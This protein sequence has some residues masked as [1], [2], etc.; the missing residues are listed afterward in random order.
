M[1][2]SLAGVLASIIALSNATAQA[3]TVHQPSPHA[4]NS[5]TFGTL[6]SGAIGMPNGATDVPGPT[7]NEVNQIYRVF[8]SSVDSAGI[9]TSGFAG[10]LYASF[11][12]KLRFS[13]G[14]LPTPAASYPLESLAVQVG[15][16]NDLPLKAWTTRIVGNRHLNS[17]ARKLLGSRITS[18]ALAPCFAE[19]WD[20]KS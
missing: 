17:L 3:E 9:E 20:G 8:Y 6:R 4:G 12:G 14:A 19:A 5:C 18:T 7:G 11:D 1:R 16:P 15:N 10:W 13:L 2:S